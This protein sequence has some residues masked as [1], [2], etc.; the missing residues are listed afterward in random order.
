MAK[1]DYMVA[2]IKLSL[3]PRATTD[4][5]TLKLFRNILLATHQKEGEAL[6]E[7]DALGAFGIFDLLDR[8][9]GVD[10]SDYVLESLADEDGFTSTERLGEFIGALFEAA[11]PKNSPSSQHFGHATQVSCEPTFSSTTA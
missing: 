4:V 9:V 1:R 11:A 10:Q 8:L 2:G 5:K 3:D 6:S 7:Q